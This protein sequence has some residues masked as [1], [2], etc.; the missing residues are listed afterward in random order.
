M[1][2]S[3]A[4]STIPVSQKDTPSIRF[5]YNTVPGRVLLRL[6]VCPWVSKA[7]GF[8]LDRKI[9]R[10]FVTPFVKSSGICLDDYE[11]RKWNSFNDFFT[12]QV[13]PGL[14]P[15]PEDK[16]ILVAP[17][18]GKLTVYPVTDDAVFRIKHSDYDLASLLEDRELADRYRG[19]T[20]LIF[21][22][23][24]DDY[25]RYGFPDDGEFLSGRRIPG[26][27]HTVR[28]IAFDHC[29]VYLRNAREYA[30]LRTAHF[31]DVIQM[32]VG[33]LFVGRIVNNPISGPFRREE[34]KG[35]FEF[36]GSTIVLLLQKDAAQIHDA[37]WVNTANGLETVVK[38][39]YPLGAAGS[40]K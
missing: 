33:A 38:K 22:L 40:S 2:R 32:E 20:C 25:H 9:S 24:P 15:L 7:A 1:L 16:T 21:R 19:G 13:R 11:D 39:G 36:G 27:L 30:L 17:C 31:G 6:L 37:L 12:R 3:E 29:P 18:D 8:V 35:K 34:E 4:Y 5:L 26:L 28:P 23:T 10:H 14:R